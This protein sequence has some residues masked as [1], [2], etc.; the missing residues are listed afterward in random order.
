MSKDAQI[1]DFQ[2]KWLLVYFW[3]LP[4]YP[5]MS[6][7]I[8]NLMKFYEEHRTQRDRFEI[9]ALCMDVEGEVK[10]VSDLDKKLQ[11]V[12]KNV[13]G[14]PL[15]FPILLDPSFTTWERYGLPAFGVPILID[16]QGN[17]VKGDETVLA[18][19]LKE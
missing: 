17:L 13:W 1:S 15:P 8:P 4:C 14:K 9:L 7:G 16:P 11:P 18:E 6:R 3:G 12:V 5:C 2:G 10:S 19:K